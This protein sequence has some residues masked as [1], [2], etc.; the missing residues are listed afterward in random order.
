MEL[1]RD[2]AII[3]RT[4]KYGDADIIATL[5]TKNGGR[6]S[7]MAKG[8]LKSRKRFGGVLEAGNRVEISFEEKPGKDFLFLKE[9]TLLAPMMPWR[10]FLE[11]MAAVGYILELAH[12]T[13]PEGHASLPKFELLSAFL[14]QLQPSN[15]K[16][17]FF[18]F[19]FHWLSL[20]GWE[21]R[22]DRCGLCEARLS[23]GEGWEE[24]QKMFDHY[25]GHILSKPL[26]ASG[27]SGLDRM[28]PK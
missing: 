14:G 9:G 12:K 5:F 3:L 10:T 25:W 6:V 13:L 1:S 28:C 23:A 18:D 24:K 7:G 20:S 15:V 11:G 26:K 8:A 16:E 4:I 2:H 21:P 19:Q 22:F 27:L 17:L